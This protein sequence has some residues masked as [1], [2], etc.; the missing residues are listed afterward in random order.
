MPP[1]AILYQVCEPR[2]INGVRKLKK[3]DG[4]KDSGAD[5]AD[6]PKS[7]NANVVT[8]EQYSYPQRDEDGAFLIPKAAL[9][10]G[11]TLLWANTILFTSHPLQTSSAIDPHA[12]HLVEQYDVKPMSA[13]YYGRKELSPCDHGRQIPESS[14]ILPTKESP[15]AM[16]QEFLT[17]QEGTVTVIAP[18]K[19]TPNYWVMPIVVRF[20]HDNGIATYKRRGAATSHSRVPLSDELKQN[21]PYAKVSEGCIRI[22]RFLGVMA[23]IWVGVRCFT[24]TSDF[25]FAAFD[26]SMKL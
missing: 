16:L 22:A 25:K 8:L 19:D 12:S 3:P 20:N 24:E 11:A 26:V 7:A 2:V 6:V 14:S 15:I 5:I 13:V 4:Y 9:E 17:G 23:P 1:V 21:L 10:K 18:S